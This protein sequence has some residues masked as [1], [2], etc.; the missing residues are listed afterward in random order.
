MNLDAQTIADDNEVILRS[1]GRK[2]EPV[3]D[4]V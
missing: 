3:Y 2:N 4:Y 1:S